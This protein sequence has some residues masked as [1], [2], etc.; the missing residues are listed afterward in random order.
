MKIFGDGFIA[1][2]LKKLKTKK[3]FIFMLLEFQIQII[4]KIITT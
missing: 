3:I 1:S 4:R 2:H